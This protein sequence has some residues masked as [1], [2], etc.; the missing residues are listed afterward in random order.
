MIIEHDGNMQPQLIERGVYVAELNAASDLAD[1]ESGLVGRGGGRRVGGGGR[2]GGGGCA[3]G[4]ERRRGGVR[5]RVRGG[6]RSPTLL[7]LRMD[8]MVG[9]DEVEH[10]GVQRLPID[11]RSRVLHG[12]ID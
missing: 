12:L 11:G 5:V 2:G 8:Q 10:E 1:E 7:I 6:R 3:L 9:L 4:G